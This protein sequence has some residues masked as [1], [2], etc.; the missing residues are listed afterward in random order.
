MTYAEI[1]IVKNNIIDIVLILKTGCSAV[2]EK[3]YAYAS[4]LVMLHCNE[5]GSHYILKQT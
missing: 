2:T 3:L 1:K 4:Q 5:T